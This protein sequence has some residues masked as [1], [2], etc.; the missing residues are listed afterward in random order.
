MKSQNQQSDLFPEM[1]HVARLDRKGRCCGRKPIEYK[2]GG[3][4]SPPGA[5]FKFC[6]TCGRHYDIETGEEIPR[7]KGKQW[8]HGVNYVTV[9]LPGLGGV[10]PPRAKSGDG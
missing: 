8:I 6:H 2:G 4:H 5:P 10:A 1:E 3:V 7:P 9:E